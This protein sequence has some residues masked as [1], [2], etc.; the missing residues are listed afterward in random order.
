MVLFPLNDKKP[1]VGKLFSVHVS[2]KIFLDILVCKT[3]LSK[4]YFSSGGENL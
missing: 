4:N 3:V 2:T 1:R